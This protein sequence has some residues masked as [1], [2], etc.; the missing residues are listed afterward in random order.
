MLFFPE[1]FSVGGSIFR[2]FFFKCKNQNFIWGAVGIFFNVKLDPMFL[3][4]RFM[5]H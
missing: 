1:Y 3:T 2:F 4:K 5:V